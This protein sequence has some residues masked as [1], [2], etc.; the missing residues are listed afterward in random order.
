[1]I[2][3]CSELIGWKPLQPSVIIMGAKLQCTSH[4]SSTIHLVCFSSGIYSHTYTCL[5][6]HNSIHTYIHTYINICMQTCLHAY[7]H[8]LIHKCIQTYIH[9]LI[10]TYLV[11]S[12][13]WCICMSF[14]ISNRIYLSLL[15]IHGHVFRG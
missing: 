2:T 1:M 4:S 14:G 5:F 11:S 13:H 6:I 10:N 9:T 7:V 12:P 15:Q 3:I 8:T